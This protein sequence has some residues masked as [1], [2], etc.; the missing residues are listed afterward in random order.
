MNRKIENARDILKKH[1][2]DHIEVDSERVA[3]E[4]LGIDFDQI[5]ELCEEI[6][7]PNIIKDIEN[8]EPVKAIN[9]SKLE[10]AELQEYIKI[11]EDEVKSGKF[12]IAIMA[13]GQGTRLGH[14]GPKGTFKIK[15]NEE[16]K[17]LFEIIVDKLK[18]AQNKYGITLRCYI[19]T[20]P[21][22]NEETIRFF[23]EANYFGYPKE[24][25][26][27][28]KQG[29]LP[30]LDKQ[31]KLIRDEKGQIKQASDGNGGIFYSMAKNGIIDDMK[32]NG[33]EW[34]FIGSVDNLLV[35]YVDTLLLGLAIKQKVKIATRTIIKNSPYERVGVLCKKNGRVK[36]IEYTEIPKKMRMAVDENDEMVY[37]ESHIMCN[38]FSIEAIERAST[39]ELKYHVALKKANYMNEKGEIIVPEE[40]NCYKFEKFVFDSF[41]LFDEIAILRG[42]REEDFAPIKNKEGVDSPETAKKL[43]ESYTNK[44]IKN[45]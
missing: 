32:K 9:P 23:E 8:I 40:P 35:K 41:C 43:Y 45:R 2:Q 22:N 18:D 37:G 28:F 39:K 42:I 31:G 10:A 25:I 34:V 29:E 16:E 44:C 1:G 26:R 4:V 3:D 21:E 11:G 24:Y 20:S 36:V 17:S 15:L 19:M 7:N 13:G 30:L 27:F 5:E 14:K 6:K 33:I 12:A 38:L